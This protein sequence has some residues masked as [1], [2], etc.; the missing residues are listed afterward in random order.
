MSR[1]SRLMGSAERS[2]QIPAGRQP[3]FDSRG[4]DICIQ[5]WRPGFRKVALT[6]TFREGGASLSEAS[7]LTEALL[8]GHE[9]C[10]YLEKFD[11]I[12]AARE[13]LT[14]IGVG[15]VCAK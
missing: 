7:E 10:M 5:G 6:R 8:E 12:D 9:V 3:R 13:T 1:P 15:S 4:I 2:V 11:S 14:E